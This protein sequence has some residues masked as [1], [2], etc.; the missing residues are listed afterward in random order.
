MPNE[1]LPCPFCGGEA[2]FT[3]KS[4]KPNDVYA[5]FLYT[6]KC[7]KCG[8]SPFAKC[9]EMNLILEANG[10]IKITEPSL[11][12]KKEMIDTWNM[13]TTERVGEE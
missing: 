9:R 3:V 10:D 1:L 6:I 2:K 5:G 4:I 12:N 13:R 11:V 7:S 8:V